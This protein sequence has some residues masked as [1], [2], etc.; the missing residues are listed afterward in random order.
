MSWVGGE[1]GCVAV[2]MVGNHL[3]RCAHNVQPLCVCTFDPNNIYWE[4]WSAFEPH[5]YELCSPYL[6]SRSFQCALKDIKGF[7][8]FFT[9]TQVKS[10]FLNEVTWL[11]AVFIIRFHSNHSYTACFLCNSFVSVT[12]FLVNVLRWSCSSVYFVW[13]TQDAVKRKILVLDLDETLIHSHHD[14]VLRPTVRPGTPPD[15]IL[16]VRAFSHIC[17]CW[18]TCA[19]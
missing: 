11:L 3:C 4:W 9:K 2:T 15:F 7:S 5:T 10:W 13:I 18:N 1:T 6:Q 8:Y 12:W 17:T 16:K 14:G 19:F